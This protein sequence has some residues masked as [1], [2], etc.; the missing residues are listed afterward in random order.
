VVDSL[1]Q[2]NKQVDYNIEQYKAAIK[3]LLDAKE[4]LKAKTIQN[5]IARSSQMEIGFVDRTLE[6]SC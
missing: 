3:E 1:N 4:T 6:T 2:K 5:R